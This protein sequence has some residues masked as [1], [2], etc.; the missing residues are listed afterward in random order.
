MRR[1][2]STLVLVA[3]LMAWL[4]LTGAQ[5]VSAGNTSRSGD[6]DRN[7]VSAATRSGR[8]VGVTTER[9]T[10]GGTRTAMTRACNLQFRGARMAFSDEYALSFNP[11][12][13]PEAAWVQPRIAFGQFT[14]GTAPFFYDEAG[15]RVFPELS[16]GYWTSDSGVGTVLLPSGALSEVFPGEPC[17]TP[18]PVA[19]VASETQH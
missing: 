7:E 13:V 16:C 15:N 3:L 1:L 2:L 17:A 14:P 11:A 12:P 6:R 18:H 19:C 10:G 9:F 4:S 8:F 5:L